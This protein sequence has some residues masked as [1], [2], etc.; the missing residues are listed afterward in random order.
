MGFIGSASP[1]WKSHSVWY[2]GR[3]MYEREQVIAWNGVLIFLPPANSDACKNLESKKEKEENQVFCWS[4]HFHSHL[5]EQHYL[6][7]VHSPEDFAPPFFSSRRISCV[8]ELIVIVHGTLGACVMSLIETKKEGLPIWSSDVCFESHK[9]LYIC[10]LMLYGIHAW[11][12][13]CTG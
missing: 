7:I 11:V 8:S 10:F 3:S 1:S 2:D 4:Y 9:P 13:L 12:G 5:S 6:L